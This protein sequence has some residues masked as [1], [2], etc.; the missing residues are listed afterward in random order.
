VRQ[1]TKYPPAGAFGVGPIEEKIH[2][3]RHASLFSWFA[4]APLFVGTALS[5]A[6][7]S[8]APQQ[9]TEA[10]QQTEN[11]LKKSKT[12]GG[13]AGLSCPTGYTCE[14]SQPTFPDQSGVCKKNFCV[15]NM[16]C[17]ISSHFDSTVCDCVPNVHPTCLTLTCQEG[18]HCDEKW[19]NGGT[20]ATCVANEDRPT[21]LTLTC[22]EG[23]HCDEKGINGG[24]IAV[25]VAN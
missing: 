6:A 13:L 25:C 1:P 10:S 11:D 3:I 24:S 4:V 23:F 14:Y 8:G 5:V 22:E 21:C 20:I 7:C 2:M 17:A 16:I 15:Q 18:F 12:C 9:G 19:I